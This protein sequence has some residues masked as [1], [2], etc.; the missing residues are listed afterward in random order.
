MDKDVAQ[1]NE[2]KNTTSQDGG[3][4]TVQEMEVLKNQDC[5]Q[6]NITSSQLASDA[7]AGCI[8]TLES[9]VDTVQ[10]NE[11]KAIRPTATLS[12]AELKVNKKTRETPQAKK[13][14][15]LTSRKRTTPKAR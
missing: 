8:S 2:E 4:P 14:H 10:V 3:R 15:V 9:H 12:S 5:H 11:D 1:I 6:K 7:L 13:K